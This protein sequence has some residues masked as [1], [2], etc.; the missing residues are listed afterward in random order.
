MKKKI[1]YKFKDMNLL[2]NDE[3]V[4]KSILDKN[5]N[6]S[7]EFVNNEDVGRGIIK[8]ILY[9]LKYY[10]YNKGIP[11]FHYDGVDYKTEDGVYFDDTLT[12]ELDGTNYMVYGTLRTMVHSSESAV[13][14]GRVQ[15][16][17]REISKC[18]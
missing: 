8:Y 5:N 6:L 18:L 15:R 17:N 3:V 11:V 7:F 12:I 9:C 4:V 14:I 10:L 2:F 13:D 1:R 16:L